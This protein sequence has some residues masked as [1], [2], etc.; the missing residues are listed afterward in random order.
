MTTLNSTPM[1]TLSPLAQSIVH[2][3]VQAH[4]S[5]MAWQ[6]EQ[7]DAA[8]GVEQAYLIQDAVA[9][10]LGWFA[11]GRATAWK[12]G[13]KAQMSAAPLPVVLPSGATWHC[14]GTHELAMEAEVAFRLGRTPI[15]PE[16]ILDCIAAM[17]VTIEMVGTRL[18]GGMSAPM[19]WK[20]ADQ[21]VHGVLAAGE[22]VPYAARDWARQQCTVTVNGV[23]KAALTGT[24][25]SGDALYPLPWLFGHAKARNRHL[26]A[27]D[28]I[29]TGA[30]AVIKVEP[31]DL[32]EV[33]F[34]DIGQAA[35]TIRKA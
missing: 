33:A 4:R 26:Q 29:T 20:L 34:A 11:A 14:A 31:G 30:W 7:F 16:D 6:P 12:G 22:E 15:G 28:L 10:E 13:G 9:A 17:C 3:L 25:P 32:I 21:Q 2:E 19:V 18:K 5:S 1:P 27:G 8:L 35:V 24:H 23:N